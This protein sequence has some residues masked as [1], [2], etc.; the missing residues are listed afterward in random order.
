MYN[1]KWLI[2]VLVL[3]L[4]ANL[5]LGGFVIGRMSHGGPVPGVM[6]PSLSLFRMMRELPERRREAF[7][8]TVREHFHDMRDE[9]RR[10]RAA[11]RG[12]N[13]A[14][15]Q[16]PFDADALE[17]ALTDF[18]AALVASQRDNHDLLVRVAAAMSHEERAILR[19][20]MVRRRPGHS[21]GGHSSTD[22]DRTH[23]RDP[24]RDAGQRAPA[25]PS[26]EHG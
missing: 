6:D 16:E 18:R 13:D 21:D 22:P 10:M 19:E 4:A 17:Q 15:E 24:A 2:I 7:R 20:A 8:P 1:R 11:Q 3:S 12:I 5:A 9:L 25:P 23:R 26:P 14:L